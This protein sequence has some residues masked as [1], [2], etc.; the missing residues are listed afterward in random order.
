MSKTK[1]QAN[2]KPKPRT[3]REWAL[4]RAGASCRI[5]IETIGKVPPECVTHGQLGYAM[6]NL[7][8]AVEDIANAMKEPK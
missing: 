2:A 5:G 3:P 8:H 4:Y 6:L 7:L 1:M